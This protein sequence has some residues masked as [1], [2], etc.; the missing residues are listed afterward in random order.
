MRLAASFWADVR[1]RG[2]PTADDQALDAD[3]I[4][5]AQA[6]L[7]GG[8]GDVVTVATGNVAHLTRFPRNDAREWSTVT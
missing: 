8:A 2:V 1:L 6:A 4:L 3:A 5:A 7:I